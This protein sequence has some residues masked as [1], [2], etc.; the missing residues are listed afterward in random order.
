MES[1]RSKDRRNKSSS[2]SKASSKRSK[3]SKDSRK[4]K[5]EAK[6]ENDRQN[7]GQPSAS[8]HASLEAAAAGGGGSATATN[9]VASWTAGAMH[10]VDATLGLALVV[11]GAMVHLTE[12]TAACVCYG[13]LLFLGA[14]GGAIGYFSGS[15][16]RR[17]LNASVGA[18]LLTCLLDVVLFI[19]VLASWDSFVK[20]LNDNSK[21]L[22]LNKSSIDTISGLKI[23]FAVIF[24]VLAVLEAFR[25]YAI[26]SI[27]QAMASSSDK[28]SPLSK[29]LKRS[30]SDSKCNWLFSL[31]GLKKEKK[32]DDFVVFDDNTSMER[33]LMW[34]GDD[35]SMQEDYLEFIPDHERGLTDFAETVPLPAPPKDRTDY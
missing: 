1:L 33:S 29:S 6:K 12:V 14:V 28:V 19:G 30:N 35:A 20:F 24:V 3:R 17:G 26:R 16:N 2:S 7:A 21:E 31:F 32:I 5:R 15:C 10:A 25:S 22:M 23:L 11:Y 13:L 4:K 8:E 9:K 18:G 34:S 27:K